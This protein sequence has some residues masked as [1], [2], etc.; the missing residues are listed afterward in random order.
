MFAK[1][2]KHV[3]FTRVFLLIDNS[4]GVTT[5]NRNIG[6]KEGVFLLSLN[7]KPNYEANC[8]RALCAFTEPVQTRS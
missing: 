7:E 5:K 8:G 1:N 4:A 2:D 6:D 3:T